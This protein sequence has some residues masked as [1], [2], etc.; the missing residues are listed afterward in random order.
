MYYTTLGNF[1]LAT[2]VLSRVYNKDWN[3]FQFYNY[4]CHRND[5]ICNYFWLNVLDVR[6]AKGHNRQ[7]LKLELSVNPIIV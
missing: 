1:S 6:Q 7:L 5:E 4:N 2:F 3:Y